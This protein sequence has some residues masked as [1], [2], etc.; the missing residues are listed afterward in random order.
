[1]LEEKR[2]LKKEKKREKIHNLPS[3]TK[4]TDQ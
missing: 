4:N 1:M 3:T 2:G